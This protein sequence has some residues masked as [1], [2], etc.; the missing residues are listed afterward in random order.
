MPRQ[1]GKQRHAY[2][3][4]IH[5]V[6]SHTGGWCRGRE[7]RELTWQ[8]RWLDSELCHKTK[9]EPQHGLT[10]RSIYKWTGGTVHGRSLLVCLAQQHRAYERE[11]DRWYLVWVQAHYTW[12]I[13][14]TQMRKAEKWKHSHTPEC[15]TGTPTAAPCISQREWMKTHPQ[16]TKLMSLVF[17]TGLECWGPAAPGPQ[18]Q[19]SN[20]MLKKEPRNFQRKWNNKREL[21]T[22]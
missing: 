6:G 12:E 18:F 13:T 15:I 7:E 19:I 11:R 22:T 3:N 1:W 20:A 8:G 10:C 5:L 17:N 4:Q 21:D 2:K 9:R 14:A 16:P